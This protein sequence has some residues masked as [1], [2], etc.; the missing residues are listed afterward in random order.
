MHA[1]LFHR[2]SRMRTHAV[3]QNPNEHYGTVPQIPNEHCGHMKSTYS[4]VH[5]FRTDIIAQVT[6]AWT[7]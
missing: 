5:R 4:C 2:K 7:L 1:R 3:P 6:H